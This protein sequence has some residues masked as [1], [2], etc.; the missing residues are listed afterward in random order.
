MPMFG[1]LIQLIVSGI[2]MGFI[3]ALVGIEYTLIWNAS[4]VLNFSHDKMITTG[5][6]IFGGTYILGLGMDFIPGILLSLITVALL[7]I[8]V[9]R[10]IFIPLRN[11][12][13]IYTI[14]ATVML[15]KIIVEAIRLLWGPVPFS[16]PG[17][18]IG[19]VKAGDVVIS[20]ANIAIIA[21]AA[22]CVLALQL[23]LYKTKPGKAMRCV[24]QNRKAAQLMGI[25]VRTVMTVTVMISMMICCLIGLLVSPLLNITTTMSN[26]IGLK[27][28]AA[29]VIG[30]FGYLP[31]AILGGLCIGIVENIASMVLPSVYKD[32]VAFVLLVGFLLIRPAGITGKTR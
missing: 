18:L 28:F 7:G 10:V 16:V 20:I 4:G 21:A 19:T 29:G 26:M 17:F 27:G 22:F 9:A 15:G 23:F 13:M 6:Y 12:T 11:M 25:D 8:V 3:Y 14:M 30:G 24:A 32:I 2:A 5:A 31:G 1:I